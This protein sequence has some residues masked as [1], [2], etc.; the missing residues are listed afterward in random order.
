MYK[1]FLLAITI[2]PFTSAS[3]TGSS[4]SQEKV[5]TWQQMMSNLP[6]MIV[7]LEQAQ[8]R[9]LDKNLY[10]YEY[11]KKMYSDAAPE[12]QMIDSAAIRLRV[13]NAMIRY[14][15]DVLN[16][17]MPAVSY[18]G[19]AGADDKCRDISTLINTSLT[20]NTLEEAVSLLETQT[21]WY[22]NLKSAYKQLLDSSDESRKLKIR[23]L[24]A[25]IYALQTVRWMDCLLKQNEYTI[26]VN[27]PSASLVLYNRDVAV[28]E[29]KVIVGKKTSRTPTF[30]SR[31]TDVTI[32][33]Y[34]MVPRSIA[35]KELLPEIK[36][37]VTYLERNNFQLV[38]ASG[39]FA[40]AK[41]INWSTMTPENFPYTIRQSTG[42]DNS[43]GL[44]KLNVNHPFNVYL[45][46]TPWK[47]LFE[48]QNRFFSHGCIRVQKAKEL[49]G[50][51]LKENRI[52]VD[53]LDE[54]RLFVG[55]SPKV[56]LLQNKIPVLVL[57]NT[58]WFDATGTVRFYHDIYSK[59]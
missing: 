25:I 18:D 45:H 40:D 20:S 4:V 14:F 9:G 8:S 41:N 43:L 29:S 12:K 2:S 57:Y 7:C 36:M 33:P 59:L 38:D 37:D 11:I 32:F 42:C 53:T 54:G 17:Q 1:Y 21:P 47:A 49:A 55:K 13:T 39:R 23:N 48:A 24:S 3:Q 26:V 5:T 16:G 22:K 28:L 50:Y 6:A 19:L 44:I 30:I 51:L 52:A 27:I 56:L 34:W 31:V 10:D 46:D 35:T 58:A 15:S